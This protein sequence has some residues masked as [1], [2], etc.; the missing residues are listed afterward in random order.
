MM[1]AV[2]PFL[3]ALI[4]RL[5]DPK[6]NLAAFGVAFSLAVLVES[7]ILMIMG[8]ATALVVLIPWT[9]ATG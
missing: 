4:A 1:A 7:P 9:T 8:A 3:A 6:H 5:A 2:G